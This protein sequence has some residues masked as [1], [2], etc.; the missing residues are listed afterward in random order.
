MTI[1]M[2]KLLVIQ[3]RILKL[4]ISISVYDLFIDSF[5][6]PNKGD[7]DDDGGEIR[8][9][10][11][12]PNLEDNSAVTYSCDV[13]LKEFLDLEEYHLHVSTPHERP[14]QCQHCEKR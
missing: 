4:Y 14:Y 3:D 11:D 13:C 2:W 1:I 12:E 8:E 9:E 10:T 7:S 6:S 5:L